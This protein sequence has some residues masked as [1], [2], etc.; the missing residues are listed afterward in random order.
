M[1][2]LTPQSDISISDAN[3]EMQMLRTILILFAAFSAFLLCGGEILW[4]GKD[5]ALWQA[6]ENVKVSF[7]GNCLKAEFPAND[8]QITGPQLRIDPSKI[9]AVSI[10]YRARGTKPGGGEL[11]FAHSPRDFSARKYWALP[12]LKADGQWHTLVVT[13]KALCNKANWFEGG[14]I[15]Q[16]RLD[17]VNKAGGTMEIKEIRLFST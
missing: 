14:I 11:Y 3:K 10:T 9:N 17:P 2:V 8:P 13:D 7:D 4:K 1:K 12:A 16:L 6:K 15:M 5:L